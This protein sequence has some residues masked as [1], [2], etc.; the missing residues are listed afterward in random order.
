M[1]IQHNL[2][3]TRRKNVS[4]S[5]GTEQFHFLW[6]FWRVWGEGEGGGV[7]QRERVHCRNTTASDS[8]ANSGQ[9]FPAKPVTKTRPLENVQPLLMVNLM[10]A[11][12]NIIFLCTF[13]NKKS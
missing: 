12:K 4:A 7:G 1:Q 10:R 11:S 2:T 3:S 9:D 13:E 8:V 6:I 5:S